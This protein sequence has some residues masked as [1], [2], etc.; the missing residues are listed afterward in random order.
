MSFPQN[1]STYS[2]LKDG[3]SIS[4][5]AV[6]PS[7]S[8]QLEEAL[9]RIKGSGSYNH[10]FDG[11]DEA[12]VRALAV[13][14]FGRSVILVATL[15]LQNKETIVGVARYEKCTTDNAVQRKESDR[16]L[17]SF[18]VAENLQGLG[19]STLL[20]ENLASI[21]YSEG[22]SCF[23]ANIPARDTRMLGVVE[24]SGLL[25]TKELRGEIVNI[26]LS[27]QRSSHFLGSSIA[28]EMRSSAESIRRLFNPKSVA[29]IGASR[30]R[31]SIGH[32][33]LRNLI[34]AGFPGP[35]YPVNP[36]A[37]SLEGIICYPSLKAIHDHVDLAVISVPAKFVEGVVSECAEAGV[38]NIVI[39]SAGFAEASAPGK[40][41]EE[42]IKK[43]VRESGMRMVGPNCMGILNA[44]PETSLNATFAPEMA[45]FG[46][47]SFLS[48]SGALGIAI[49]DYSKQLNI[50]LSTFVSVGNK[51]DVSGNDLLSY[52]A[53]DPDTKV[54]ALYLESFGNPRK[55][56][57]IAPEV[58]CKKP[59]IAV[60]S[61]RSSAGSRA[62]SSH[63]ASLASLDVAVDALFQQA[64]VI[65]TDTLEELFDVATLLSTQGFPEGNR[66]GVI[67]NA[68]GP[69][70]LLADALES[71]GLTLPIL[72]AETVAELRTFLPETAG[73]SNPIDMIA[74]AGPVEYKRAVELV[75]SDPSVDS[76][77][78]IYV[79]P[80]IS[81]PQG[82]AAAIAAAAGKV[83]ASKPVLTVFLSS[84]GAP[85]ILSSGPRGK[86]PAFS[87]PENA[88]RAL[89]SAE[90]YS[91]WRRKPCGSEVIF[92]QPTRETVRT[93]IADAV[94]GLDDPKWLAP[95]DI[96]CILSALGITF[97]KSLTVR[98]DE[99]GEKAKEIGFP[100]VAK[101]IV[102][103]LTH[104]S[105]IGGVVL[106]L[107]SPAD[108]KQAV[109]KIQ[110][111]VIKAG[112]PLEGILLQRQINA[113]V[114]AIIGMTSDP[115]F[116]PIVLC[117]LGGTNVELLKDVSFRLP[118]VTDV[119]AREMIDS[120]K[121][122]KLLSGYRG[123]PAGDIDALTAIITRVSALAEIAPEILEMDL[124]PVKVLSPGEGAVV[125]DAR[126]R[127][128]RIGPKV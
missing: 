49:L 47:V 65:R 108:V 8:G 33:L 6:R 42:R 110:A 72:S 3:R 84:K 19:I 95:D 57:R 4:I 58:A 79:P 61:G 122:R 89:A 94:Y 24:A 55:F 73:Y 128:N 116:G 12:Q 98:P 97:A 90:W 41:A 35:I 36:K 126:I 119:A 16:A 11:M 48:Q 124:N 74:A 59:I 39:I 15:R 2:L 78:V 22:V 109:E 54:I 7:D 68:G 112:V 45:I 30:E 114:E 28:R 53:T 34:T 26:L 63:T 18:T 60:K 113:G 121:L 123:S 106:N 82:V 117:G 5:R 87:F 67:T 83:P 56:A 127:V 81:D 62:A 120:L 86:L 93:I 115:L 105:D 77:I 64:G 21:A 14:D 103:A 71:R 96:E 44:N 104:K 25:L 76:L 40:E 88:A 50:G 111:N 46:N 80:T 9:A 101:A 10:F 51:A 17:V 99:A 38:G 102:P 92:D 43:L 23:S 20:L 29:V 37:E 100:L 125:V 75:G 13:P 107:S 1:Y 91:R 70:I 27:T 66:A 31:N 52:W 118:P 32:T 85:D 69:G